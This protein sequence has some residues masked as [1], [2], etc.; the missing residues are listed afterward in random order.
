MRLDEVK[1]LESAGGT[2]FPIVPCLW[3]EIDK[4]FNKRGWISIS[5]FHSP[6]LKIETRA[7]YR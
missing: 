1:K 2:N 4:A 7:A 6:Q 5:A 3:M